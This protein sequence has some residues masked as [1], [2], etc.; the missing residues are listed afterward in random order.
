MIALDPDAILRRLLE[1][2][3]DFVV[4]GSLAV[5][6][7]GYVRATKDVDVVPDPNAE[8]LKRLHSALTSLDARPVEVGDFRPEEL[9][10]PFGLAGLE[11]GGNWALATN[12]GRLDVMQSVAG[13]ESYDALRTG[14]LA[15]ELPDVGRVLFTG[16]D[17]LVSMKRAAGRTDDRRDL[18][19]LREARRG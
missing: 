18:E 10:V 1:H 14:A 12:C 9:P 19:Q 6:A 13:V 16:Y 5:A 8:N 3:V 4:I 2:Q 11:G 7:H 17:D 15:V